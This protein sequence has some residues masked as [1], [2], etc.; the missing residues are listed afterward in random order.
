ML[1][2]CVERTQRRSVASADD[3]AVTLQSCSRKDL[4]LSRVTETSVI[5]HVLLQSIFETA[6]APLSSMNSRMADNTINNTCRHC[7][8]HNFNQEHSYLNC[9]TTYNYFSTECSTHKRDFIA[10]FNT[11]HLL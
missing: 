2:C 9:F 11:L 7:A 3:A 4:K 5:A 1:G 6:T 10:S 8:H